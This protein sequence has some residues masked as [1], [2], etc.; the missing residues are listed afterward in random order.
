L[1]LKNG[2]NGVVD[3]VKIKIRQFEAKYYKKYFSAPPRGFEGQFDPYNH[4]LGGY[5]HADE[6]RREL[7]EWMGEF[8]Y[9]RLN[10]AVQFQDNAEGMM[11]EVI[12]PPDIEAFIANVWGS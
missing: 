9:E 7:T 8:D 6:L 11:Y 2:W 12:E 1:A 5:A 4:T 10:G 3:D